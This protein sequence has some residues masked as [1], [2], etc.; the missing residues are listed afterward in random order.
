MLIDGTKDHWLDCD[1]TNV[2]YATNPSRRPYTLDIK[3][4]E[5]NADAEGVT[6]LLQNCNQQYGLVR[7]NCSSINVDSTAY[8][9]V[10]IDRLSVV[11][12]FAVPIFDP[13]HVLNNALDD[14]LVLDEWTPLKT[15][16]RKTYSP[17]SISIKN[18][19][20]LK[21]EIR[22]YD[23]IDDNGD[24]DHYF[25]NLLP[26]KVEDIVGQGLAQNA[27]VFED[28]N[29]RGRVIQGLKSQCSYNSYPP[30]LIDSMCIFF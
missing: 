21:N 12:R 24:M 29:D 26:S 8:N 11:H 2:I 13:C 14:A 1:V 10:A 5:A 9:Q 19:R 7:D 28:E 30:R 4:R 17:F 22:R 18:R 25:E 15:W 16:C 23:A 27:I 6:E 3:F 20:W